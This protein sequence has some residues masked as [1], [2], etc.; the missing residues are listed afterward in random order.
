MAS[1]CS[2]SDASYCAGHRSD[3]DSNDNLRGPS[4]RNTIFLVLA[5]VVLGLFI[6]YDL[7]RASLRERTAVKRFRR[8]QAL[9]A[10]L[11]NTFL[12]VRPTS[13]PCSNIG[14]HIMSDGG[15]PRPFVSGPE[16]VRYARKWCACRDSE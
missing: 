7:I 13:I 1:G 14:V 2:G 5:A 4:R 11:S 12:Q 9:N 6:A 15:K 3:L 8:E 16:M 10:L